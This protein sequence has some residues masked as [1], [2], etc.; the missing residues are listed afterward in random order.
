MRQDYVWKVS[1]R[2]FHDYVGRMKIMTLN[3]DLNVAFGLGLSLGCHGLLM[4]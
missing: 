2:S 4:L 3:L 1:W